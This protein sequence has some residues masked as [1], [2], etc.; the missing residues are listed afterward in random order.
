MAALSEP[1]DYKIES[2]LD[3]LSIWT[4]PIHNS[5]SLVD[6]AA[7]IDR[8]CQGDIIE[9]DNTGAYVAVALSF[10]IIVRSSGSRRLQSP[11]VSTYSLLPA[12]GR[13]S[14][15]DFAVCSGYMLYT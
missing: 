4:L 10:Q 7:D 11:A 12:G 2:V 9:A 13:I 14:R 8:I 6:D 5:N 15:P 3:I 1:A